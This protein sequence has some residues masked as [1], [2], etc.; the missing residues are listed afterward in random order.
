MEEAVEEHECKTISFSVVAD[1]NNNPKR[2]K[3]LRNGRTTLSMETK[4]SMPSVTLSSNSRK[5]RQVSERKFCHWRCM[6][7]IILLLLPFVF[8][9]EIKKVVSYRPQAVTWISSVQHDYSSVR[10]INDLN[11]D[12]VRPKCF[13]SF[14]L[15]GCVNHFIDF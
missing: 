2:K 14:D 6:F 12:I 15:I 11:S 5:A 13:V 10:G 9:N 7:R 1:S 3:T 4:F 8:Y